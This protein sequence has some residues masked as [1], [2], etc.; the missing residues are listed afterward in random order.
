MTSE[1]TTTDEPKRLDTTIPAVSKMLASFARAR[2]EARKFHRETL[3]TINPDFCFNDFLLCVKQ[4][5]ALG[6]GGKRH[7]ALARLEKVYGSTWQD[8][9]RQPGVTK[10]T[11]NA[12][13]ES[14]GI[15]GGY[16]VPA[17][18][19]D[20]VLEAVA[21]YSVFRRHGAIEIE[22]DSGTDN[23]IPVFDYANLEGNTLVTGQP[24]YWGGLYPQIT[25]EASA[26]V[27]SMPQSQ[28][29]FRQISLH[30]WEIAFLAYESRNMRQ[31]HAVSPSTEDALVHGFALATGYVEDY[32]FFQGNG[33]GEPL[34]I[35][36]APG[37]LL[38]TRGGG[39]TIAVADVQAMR[40]DILPLASETAIWVCQPKVT[41][42]LTAVTGWFPNG[43]M[44]LYGRQIVESAKASTLGSVGD[45]LLFSPRLYLIG[46]KKNSNLLLDYSEDA[47]TPW[48]A[49]QGVW[50]MIHRV[51]GQ[52]WLASTVTL[53][54]QTTVAA[55]YVA[56]K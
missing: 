9:E 4:S 5:R 52:P 26:T 25:P 46:V 1:R 38:V 42:K 34:G 20:A 43:P 17:S 39:G 33:V 36:N 16:L 54:D 55:A 13:A 7:S 41:S 47:Q 56:L 40:G 31:D 48:L 49:N 53:E 14:S 6:S 19:S 29:A 35:V 15:T 45:L 24:P 37:T 28:P 27:T 51:D 18:Y 44:L 2:G 11:G 8:A 3:G 32:L 30:P 21:E 50:R 22:C 12:M 10:S 23:Q